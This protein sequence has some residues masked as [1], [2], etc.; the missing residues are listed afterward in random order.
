MRLV[1]RHS[2][3]V[4]FHFYCKWNCFDIGPKWSESNGKLTK[5]SSHRKADEWTRF[6][7]ASNDFPCNATNTR[8]ESNNVHTRT[9]PM[10]HTHRA[11]RSFLYISRRQLIILFPA[12]QQLD[13]CNNELDLI[14]EEMVGHTDGG[15]GGGV[16][17]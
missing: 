12:N 15:R 14:N 9:H 10:K 11:N 2:T 1:T 13:V 8:H 4:G 5:H 17:E 3:S 16:C 6:V 7:R